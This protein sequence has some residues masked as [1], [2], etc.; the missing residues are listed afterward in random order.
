MKD[1]GDQ[2][3]VGDMK[4]VCQ[5]DHSDKAA[6]DALCELDGVHKAYLKGMEKNF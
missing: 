6:F 1:G 3:K 2:E 5:R 4:V